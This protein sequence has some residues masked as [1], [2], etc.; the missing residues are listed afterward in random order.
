MYSILLADL[1]N[2]FQKLVGNCPAVS[3]RGLDIFRHGDRT[4][5]YSRNFMHQLIIYEDLEA[6]VGII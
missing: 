1:I 4:L 3:V 6:T 2:K 5:D